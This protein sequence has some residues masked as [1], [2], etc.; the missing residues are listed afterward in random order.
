MKERTHCVIMAGGIGSRFWPMSRADRPKQFLDFLGTGRSLLQLTYDRFLPLCA[1]EHIHVVTNARYKDLVLEQLPA[2]SPAQVLCEPD[3]RN[4]APCVAYASQVVRAIDPQ[5]LMIVAPSDHIVLKEQAFHDA[6]RTA[7]RQADAGEHLVTLGI[8][9][10]RPDTGYGYIRFVDDPGTVAPEVKRVVAFT[11][12]PDHATAVRFLESGDHLWN[13]GIF[14]WSLASIDRAFHTHLPR[15]K[16][17]FDSGAGRYGTDQEADQVKR[18]YDEVENVSIDYGIMER[19]ANVRTVVSDIGWSDLGTWGSLYAQLPKDAAQNAVVGG[20]VHLYECSGNM[21]HNQDD[22]LLVMQ[23]LD[24]HIVVN[25][26]H[27]V[28]VCRKHDEQQIRR[29]VDDLK[30]P[31]GGRHV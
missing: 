15:M 30:Q 17:L 22:R 23:G 8:K 20:G 3:R 31:D 6:V 18:I 4:T 28:L 19:A 9:P 7:L 21:V 13:A 1:P 14:V 5:A 29:F 25:T 16:A 2:L 24:D 11:E 26:P 27:A 10:D 12:K